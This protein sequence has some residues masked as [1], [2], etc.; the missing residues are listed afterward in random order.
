M[1]GENGLTVDI[2]SLDQP[3]KANV[4]KMAILKYRKKPIDESHPEISCTQNLAAQIWE[5]KVFGKKS[6]EIQ[7]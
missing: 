2:H 1:P 5:K 3:T 7:S 4:K 6:K